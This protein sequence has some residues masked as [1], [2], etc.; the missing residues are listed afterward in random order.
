[1]LYV[2]LGWGAVEV[3]STIGQVFSWPGWL[4]QSIVIVIFLGLPVAI[5]VSWMFDLTPEGLLPDAAPSASGDSTT[6]TSVPTPPDTARIS[7]PPPQPATPLL[8]REEAI[9][10]ASSHLRS[11]VRVLTVTGAG[12]TGKTRFSV[13]LFHRLHAEYP[14]GAAFVSLASVEDAAEVMP[15]V[16]G[17]LDIAEAHGRSAVDAVATVIGNSH[18]LLILD[19]LEQVLDAAGDIAELVSRCPGLQV[20]A[21]SR[22][23]LK[24]RAE[25]ELPLPPLELPPAGAT[26]PEDLV[27][28]PAVDL[29]V[30]RAQKVKAGF[31]VEAENG[32][33]IV[34]ICRRLDGLPLALELAA[35]RI[36]ILEPQALLDRLDHALDVLTSGDRDL[37]ARQRTL[38]ATVNWSYGLLDEGEQ[39]LLRGLSAFS[40][41]WTYEAMESVCFDPQSRSAALDQLDS[42]VEKGL[43]QVSGAGDRY[44]LLVTIRD[45]AAE[46]LEES[47]EAEA[48]R[49]AHAEYFL[50][51]CKEVH[52]GITG[53]S[54]L[55]AMRRARADSANILLA[56]HWLTAEANEQRGP[57]LEQALLLAGY[58][59]W[60][61]HITG[62]HLTA[63]TAVD[64]VLDLAAND[65]P[66]LG[67]SLALSTAGMVSV[68]T[69]EVERGAREWTE[70][71]N[72]GKAI[73]NEAAMAQAGVGLGF[74]HVIAGRLDEAR[75]ILEET[76]ERSERV[77]E[78][79]MHAVAVSFLGTVF[80]VSGDIDEGIALI[81]RAQQIS[82]R[83]D[84]YEGRGV[85]LSFL[86]QL[87][88]MKGDVDRALEHYRGSLVAL[89][90]VGDR[91]EIARVHGEMGWAAL[92]VKRVS[93]ARRSFLSSLRWYDEVGSKRGVGTALIGL[94]VAEAMDGHAERAV[95]IAAAAEVLADQAGVIIV[96]AMGI[97]AGDQ[98]EALRG[99]FDEESLARLTAAGRAMSPG[100]VVAM[101]TEREAWAPAGTG[102][103]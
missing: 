73:G 9:E 4:V 93:G 44:L 48:I 63:R 36:R 79:F 29:F 103:L 59:N 81:E 42:L 10:G 34:A 12:G 64:A 23:P 27:R 75:Q 96:H 11:G 97:G 53:R 17:A 41:G 46:L 86:A 16:A 38:R 3:T 65:P 8:G 31:A 6:A 72:D 83:I 74:T 2:A 87:H 15:A 70:S 35:A 18:V 40:E 56:L 58:Q 67:R 55:E 61:W 39:R 76:I 47:Q 94:A 24:I 57:A 68:S 28:Y 89:E 5:A 30:Q 54:Q 51:L 22:A 49:R 60:I 85:G 100:E 7:S 80:G 1:M 90:A 13:E 43:V 77:G 92:S 62:Q 99:T 26:A 37:P 78:E 32:A 25:S 71:Y 33:A 102:T 91:P 20:I 66:S 21:T 88:F 82:I 98:I 14:G 84:D 95:T 50:R 69:G 19:N 52:E 101:V 45:F